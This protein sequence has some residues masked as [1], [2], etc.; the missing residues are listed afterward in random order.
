MPAAASTD[1]ARPSAVGRTRRSQAVAASAAT[2]TASPQPVA[3]VSATTRKASTASPV[4]ST[5]ASSFRT[6]SPRIWLVPS[7]GQ[8]P[9]PVGSSDG[10]APGWAGTAA[11]GSPGARRTSIT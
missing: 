6:R 9:T 3:P 8:A 11:T 4:V 5:R 7:A 2:A 10:C 1:S